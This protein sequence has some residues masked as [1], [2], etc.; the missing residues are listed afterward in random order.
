MNHIKIENNEYF[1]ID[2]KCIT[3]YLDEYIKTSLSKF[4]SL[5]GLL[6]AWSGNLVS[7]W[8]NDFI[9]ELIDSNEELNVPILV[10]E[11][12]CD[13]SCVV[14]VIHIRKEH[15]KVCWDRIGKVNHSNWKL[16][17]EQK[18]GILCLSSYTDDD[19]KKYGDNIAK[20]QYDSDEYWEWVGENLY[21]EH[22]RRLHNYLKPY[23]QKEENIEWIKDVNWEFDAEEYENMVKK[24]REIKKSEDNV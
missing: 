11:D 20:V 9:W 16:E 2:N 4:D 22:I 21:E 23:M 6:P 13:F 8:D 24:Y 3:E 1:Y 17:D 12:D 14:I 19:W 7:E 10:C 5:Q 15:D 18:N